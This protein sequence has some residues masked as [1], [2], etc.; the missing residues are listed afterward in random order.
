[1]FIT[2]T[3]NNSNTTSSSRRAQTPAGSKLIFQLHYTPNGIEQQDRSYVGFVYAKANEVTRIFGRGLR[4]IGE[5][6]AGDRTYLAQVVSTRTGMSQPDAE[7]RVSQVIE[8]ARSAADAARSAAA[9]LSLWLT[10][11]MLVG[12]FSASLAAIEGGQLRDGT[13]KGV[14]GTSKYRAHSAV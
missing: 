7:K 6:P 11:A 14:I 10:A 12:A 5:I 8:Q 3:A 13:W 2:V 9:K 1:M 4:E